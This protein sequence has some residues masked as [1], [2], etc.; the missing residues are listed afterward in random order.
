MRNTRIMICALLA[1]A[2]SVAAKAEVLL[3]TP[4]VT[5]EHNETTGDYS[6][7]FDLG[8]LG[9]DGGYDFGNLLAEMGFG[10]SGNYSTATFFMSECTGHVEKLIMSCG[11][12]Q[13]RLTLMDH[14]GRSFEITVENKASASIYVDETRRSC[15]DG[16]QRSTSFDLNY[17]GDYITVNGISIRDPKLTDEQRRARERI[18]RNFIEGIQQIASSRAELCF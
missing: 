16:I 9:R 14:R 8:H 2:G 10:N 1:M 5:I 4:R 15:S 17:S 6:F 3:D 13:R 7:K 11:D 12:H 18:S